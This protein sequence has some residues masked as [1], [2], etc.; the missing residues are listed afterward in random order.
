MGEGKPIKI[1]R[2]I[3]RLN[4]GGPAKHVAWLSAG[5]KPEFE[6]VLV[7]GKVGEN[8]VDIS[9]FSRELGVEPLFVKE[10]KSALGPGDLKAFLEIFKIIWKE[11][12]DIVA[13]HTAK[14]GFLGRGAAF[15]ISLLRF[16]KI[17]TVHTFHGHVFHGYWGPRK[18]K[19]FI[20]LE[21]VMAVISHKIIVLS[22][23]QLEEI[24]QEFKVGNRN[25]FVIIPLGLDLEA[26]QGEALAAASDK[27]LAE[28][29]FRIGSA[30]RLT[31]VKNYGLIVE[32]LKGTSDEVHAFIAGEGEELENLTLLG[33]AM[34]LGHRFHLIGPVKNL[35]A[36]YPYLDLFVL[37]SQNEGTPLAMIEA[38]A[39][40]LPILSTRAGGVVD[41]LGAV[42]EK[43]GGLWVH[44]R[45]L[46]VATEDALGLQQGIELTRQDRLASQK[47]AERAKAFVIEKSS[48]E[49][50]IRDQKKLYLEIAKQLGKEVG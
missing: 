21:K 32:G 26:F 44:E 45:G 11:K 5:L 6:T 29:S 20:F 22:Q 15:V 4:M 46:S 49:R 10:L 41:L 3:A 34:G 17:P 39:Y 8:E 13:T 43:R 48:V 23:Q 33:K 36:F 42:E 19:L 47:R 7:A 27:L 9:Y 12:P 30:G 31:G 1:L 38:M 25:K 16:K 28:N 35:M 24:N 50:L 40:G 37:T 14:A 2:I 18:T